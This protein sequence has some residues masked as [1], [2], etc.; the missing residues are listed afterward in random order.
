MPT[1]SKAPATR[2][3]RVS[4]HAARGQAAADREL[5][6]SEPTDLAERRFFEEAL[7][8]GGVAQTIIALM[9]HAGVTQTELAARLG[10]TQ[11]RISQILRSENMNLSTAADL[12]WALGYRLELTP[13]LVERD[14]TPAVDDPPPPRWLRRTK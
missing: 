10:L 4:A 12:A 1:K 14:G 6:T 7:L 5:V 2:R 8:A 13:R 9:E 11:P 3:K